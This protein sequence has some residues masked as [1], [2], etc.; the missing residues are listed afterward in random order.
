MQNFAIR[1]DQIFIDLVPFLF[2]AYNMKYIKGAYHTQNFVYLL[3]KFE[4]KKRLLYEVYI[5]YSKLQK[6]TECSL[7]S[8]HIIICRKRKEKGKSTSVSTEFSRFTQIVEVFL[9]IKY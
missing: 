8:L 1:N 7:E 2:K 3:V 4:M 5:I 9:Q 6:F